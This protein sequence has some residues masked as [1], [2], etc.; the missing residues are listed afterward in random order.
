VS[1]AKID[2]SAHFSGKILMLTKRLKSRHKCKRPEA[3]N[4]GA[5][6]SMMALIDLHKRLHGFF[7]PYNA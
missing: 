2:K 1:T 5:E 3:W 4:L 7:M 6:V